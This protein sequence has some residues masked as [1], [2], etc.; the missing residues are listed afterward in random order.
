M[1]AFLGGIYAV[2]HGLL[3]EGHAWAL[4]VLFL[5]V[6]LGWSWRYRT[7]LR[8]QRWVG[9]M[10][11]LAALGFVGLETYPLPEVVRMGSL[12]GLFLLGLFAFALLYPSTK[13][14]TTE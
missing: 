14:H 11:L 13:D 8:Q 3:Q 10:A 7:L 1:L 2:H 5:L 4:V 12:M 6:I 9:A